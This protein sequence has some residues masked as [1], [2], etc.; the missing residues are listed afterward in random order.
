MRIGTSGA[1][2]IC[3]GLD[4]PLLAIDT[5]KSMALGVS[6]YV[7]R[8]DTLLCPMLDARRMEVYT[9]LWS[10]KLEKILPVYPLIVEEDAFKQYLD[11]GKVVFFGDGAPKCREIIKHSNAEFIADIVP[12][13]QNIGY[14][15][16]EEYE[17]GNFED[18][19]LFEP[20]YLKPFRTTTPRKT[21]LF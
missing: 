21:K 8:H 7:S 12:S 14:L 3:F 15:A 5:L 11:Q 9:S 1:K 17:K 18:L 10:T 16:F 4:I 13:A 20:N 19:A 6:K 2:G